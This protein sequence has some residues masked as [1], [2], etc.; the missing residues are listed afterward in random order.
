[1]EAAA[2]FVE[3]AVVAAADRI[4]IDLAERVSNETEPVEGEGRDVLP[5]VEDYAV[6]GEDEAIEELAPSAGCLSPRGVNRQSGEGEAARSIAMTLHLDQVAVLEQ[7]NRKAK[8]RGIR[9]VAPSDRELIQVVGNSDQHLSIRWGHPQFPTPILVSF[10]HAKRQLV[11]RQRLWEGL[12]QDK[13]RQGPWYVVGDFNLVVSSVSV[14]HLVRAPSDHAPLHISFA[15]RVVCRSPMFRF[16][17]VWPSKD[18]FLDMVKTTWQ[19]EVSGSPFYV[20]WGK[21]RNVSRTLHL[22]NKYVFGDVFENV[23]KGEEVMAAA[24]LRAQ[25][26]LSVVAH[27]ELQHAQQRRFQTRIHKIQ[28]SV[29]DWVKDDEGIGREAVRYFSNLFSA[30]PVTEFQLLHVIPNL[31]D[32]ID[33]MRL[34][35]VPSLE[36][37]KQVIFDMDGD[38]SIGSD[39]FTGKFFTM[40]W[41]VVAHDVYRAISRVVGYKVP[42]YCPFVSHLAFAD[43]VI[44]FANG[45]ADSLKRVMQILECYQSDFG[46]LVNVQKSGYLVHPR[47]TVAR[48]RVIE[49]V[50]H[51]HKRELPVRYLGAPLFI[52]RAKEAYYSDLCQKVLDKVLSWKF[53]LLS[54]GRKLILIRHVLSS[55]PIHLLAVG[56]IP[57]GTFRL[58]ERVCADFL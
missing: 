35:E 7:G 37:V 24:E 42:R 10:V 33:N 18:E 38:S 50:T 41:E 54:F 20:V 30:E 22:W 3:H 39:D 28:D 52:G 14:S 48:K 34:E 9:A 25:S 45:G 49:R 31:G 15:S 5:G 56:V 46:Q 12:L 21:L 44:V 13:L 57:K 4:I 2:E 26:D 8:E 47:I 16:L 36:E 19:M 23:K 51:F 29:G 6:L 17:N 53:H 1:M 40:A 27:L 58:I 55:I 43:D 11:E 32:D